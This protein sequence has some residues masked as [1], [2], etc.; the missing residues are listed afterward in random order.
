MKT[1]STSGLPPA[2]LRAH[3]G[4]FLRRFL[5][6]VGLVFAASSAAAAS[7]TSAGGASKL[8]FDI[9]A[10]AAETSLKLFSEQSGRGVIFSTELLRGVRTNSVQGSY[11]IGEAL[12][13]VL[14]RTGLIATLDESTGAFAI[15]KGSAPPN[16]PRAGNVTPP[17]TVSVDEP[18][19]T[20][21]PFE[22]TSE[23]DNGYKATNALSGTRFNTNLLDLPKP[24]EVI[25]SEFIADIGATDMYEATR[26]A[27]GVEVNSAPG[28]DDITGSN[29]AVRGISVQ[30][31]T[32]RNGY[33]SFGIVDPSTIERIEIIKGPS[34][35]FSG[36]I[37]P[38]GT[39]NAI[40]KKP[41]RTRNDAV[42]ASWG[43]FARWRTE[44][45]SSAPI[46]AAKKLAYRAV[47]VHEEHGSPYD[48]A[49][50]RRGAYAVTLDYRPTERTTLTFDSSYV[51][52]FVRPSA[53]IAY[54]NSTLI[55][56]SIIG[57]E[58]NIR[59]TF[60]RQ[61]PHAFSDLKQAQAN[62]D[63]THVFNDVWS[64]RLGTYFRY[65][66]L[67]RLL[68]GGTTRITTNRTTGVRTAV[69]TGT[70]E[71]DAESYV[72]APQAYVTGKF[73]YGGFD[74]RMIAGY[75]YSTSPTRNDVFTRALAPIDIDN[76][77]PESYAV[78]DPSTYAPNDLRRTGAT[79]QGYSLNNVWAFWGGRATFL[80]GM[81]YGTFDSE[82]R[83]LATG[84]RST[85][86]DSAL[87]QSYGLSAR[88]FPKVSAFVSYSES[89][90]PQTLFDFNGELLEPVRGKGTD[91]GLKYDI[92]DG[93]LSG[94]LV[95]FDITRSNAPTPDPDHPGFFVADAES[96]AQGFETSLL[97]RLVD[98]WSV[99]A[100]Y[101]YISTEITKE[102]RTNLIGQRT[103]NVPRHQFSVWNRY[104]FSRGLLKGL[105]AGVGVSY[106]GNRRGNASVVDM[107]GLQLEAYTRWDANVSYAFKLGRRDLG[108]SF[109]VSNLTDEGYQVNANGFAEPRSYRGS[110]SLRF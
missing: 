11:T 45:I 23:R 55:N 33:K 13:V 27:S 60:N 22:V 78:G 44:L 52:N 30:T 79:E 3:L 2:L 74:H 71:P 96:R 15:R 88:V 89:F 58:P 102:N 92:V 86:S 21:S 10:G 9:P 12:G 7:A 72:H 81:R 103:S 75:E 59:P 43:S 64:F 65:Q 48:F 93:R 70:W 19:V 80:Q 32:Y 85:L 84:L 26:Y 14:A 49:G 29:F 34:S 50:R 16:A 35:V 83:N 107:P 106:K 4:A 42:K 63:L 5:L 53:R 87:A 41:S 25:T 31:T 28:Q 66:D 94:S 110:A 54:F 1:A 99:V 95:G 100:S 57:L 91:V 69:R 77:T 73:R 105:G 24:V 109:S 18:A 62:L 56:S 20:L 40:T 39:I 104:R 17:A 6:V 46:D 68:I 61:G 36:T 108:L 76:P 101:A 38:G 90:A 51:E 97:T 82:R 67:T 47:W 98:E 8:K 37:E